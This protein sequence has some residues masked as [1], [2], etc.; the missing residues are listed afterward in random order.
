[1]AGFDYLEDA[2][3]RMTD[4]L[5]L[6]LAKR[7]DSAQVSATLLTVRF[8]LNQWHVFSGFCHYIRCHLKV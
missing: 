7:N 6:V 3:Q 4:W 8:R 2:L 1:M 5:L